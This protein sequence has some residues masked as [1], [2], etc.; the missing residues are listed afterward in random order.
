MCYD[1]SNIDTV[2][3]FHC[4]FEIWQMRVQNISNIDIFLQIAMSVAADYC[5]EKRLF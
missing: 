3:G 5:K 2:V 4:P 1:I